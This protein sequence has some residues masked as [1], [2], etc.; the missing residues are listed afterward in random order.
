LL[1]SKLNSEVESNLELE[2]SKLSKLFL[3][4]DKTISLLILFFLFFKF[5]FTKNLSF[6]CCIFK[7]SELNFIELNLNKIF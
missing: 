2:K 5:P 1:K 7:N 4:I 6:F 3:K